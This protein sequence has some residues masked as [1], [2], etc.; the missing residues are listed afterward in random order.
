MNK[1]L[2]LLLLVGACTVPLRAQPENT[3]QPVSNTIMSDFCYV[4][5]SVDQELKINFVG[6]LPRGPGLDVLVWDINRKLVLHQEVPYGTYKPEAPFVL[7]VPKDGAAGE[8]AIKLMGQ[9]DNFL[10]LRRP[11]TD[12]PYE[13]YGGKGFALGYAN[14]RGTLRQVAFKV[15]DGVTKISLEGWRGFLRVRNAAGAVIADSKENGKTTGTNRHPNTSI[16]ISLD[17]KPGEVYWIEPYDAL[18]FTFQE[19]AYLVFNP[20][21]WFAPSPKWDFTN[22]EW[23][24]E[25]AK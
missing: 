2:Q 24:K 22:F 1:C 17:V 13:V 12:L 10:A 16:S 11:L 9:Q 18:Y 23:W 7:T 8:Y 4:R 25:V 20:N 5:E 21:R 19:P 14:E 6:T 3:A 15:P